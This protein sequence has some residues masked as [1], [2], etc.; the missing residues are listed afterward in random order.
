MPYF[1]IFSP[2]LQLAKFDKDCLYVKK[3]VPE[4]KDVDKKI[5]LKWEK[6]YNKYPDIKYYKPMVDIKK[7]SKEFVER[8]K[9]YK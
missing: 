7:T 9:K 8:F 3:W 6:D 5:I 2:I 4:L 1:R